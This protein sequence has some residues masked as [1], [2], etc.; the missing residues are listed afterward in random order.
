M[1]KCEEN[2]CDNKHYALGMCQKHYKLSSRYVLYSAW[3]NMHQRCENPQYNYYNI[4]GG[5]G[6]KVCDRWSGK[7]GLINFLSDMS[8]KTTTAHTLDR[9][10]N[11]GDYSPENCRWATPTEQNLNRRLQ[12]NNI[13]GSVGVGWA[14]RE[15]KWRARIVRYGVETH[16]GYFNTKNEAI[17][18]RK[19]A[20]KLL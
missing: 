5:R 4:Y 10:N 9:I 17:L 13:S 7:N 12:S 19:R 16:I 18:A 6:I 20:E 1:R 8:P 14:K 11:D 3:R 15:Y 2:G